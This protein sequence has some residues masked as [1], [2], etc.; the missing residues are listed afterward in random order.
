VKKFILI[1]DRL[2]EHSKSKFRVFAAE[3]FHSEKST[4]TSDYLTEVSG[5]TTKT[6]E[7]V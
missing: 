3:A 6:F 7:S 5:E 4:E 1:S 2:V